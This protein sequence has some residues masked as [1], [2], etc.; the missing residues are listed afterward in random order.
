MT[1]MIGINAHRPVRPVRS[2]VEV[3]GVRWP[4]H[5][6]HA[7]VAGV[8]AALVTLVLFSSAQAAAWVSAVVV[9]AVWWGERYLAGKA[10]VA[11]RSN[12]PGIS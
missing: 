4:A 2:T 3:F 12:P 9:L 1:A 6:A 8:V 10:A 11:S 5:K 7:V